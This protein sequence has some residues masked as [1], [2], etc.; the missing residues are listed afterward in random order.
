MNFEGIAHIR[1]SKDEAQA[2]NSISRVF[3][4]FGD[5]F[6]SGLIASL[7]TENPQILAA[8]PD[9]ALDG[10]AA[11]LIRELTY[12][13]PDRLITQGLKLV[14]DACQRLHL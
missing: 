4:C 2:G 1:G 13:E 12:G 3:R 9:D 14:T 6:Q 8:S 11:M 7:V 5:D 10:F